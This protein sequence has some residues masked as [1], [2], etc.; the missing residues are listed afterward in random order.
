MIDKSNVIVAGGALAGAAAGARYGFRHAP[1]VLGDV[2]IDDIYDSGVNKY[3]LKDKIV[4][5]MGEASGDSFSRNLSDYERFKPKFDNYIKGT[6]EELGIDLHSK[7][8][9][10]EQIKKLWE[11]HHIGFKYFGKDPGVTVEAV[12]SALEKKAAKAVGVPFEDYQ[13]ARK[14]IE[15]LIDNAPKIKGRYA[16]MYGAAGAAAAGFLAMISAAFCKPS[17]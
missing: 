5:Y 11:K 10:P 9:T 1:S 4:K 13:Y 2:T 15:T 3:I 17:K 7:T 16:A 12:V 14:A 6:L 8:L